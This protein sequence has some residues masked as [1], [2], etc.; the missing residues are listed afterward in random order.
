IARIFPDSMRG[1][2][3]AVEPGTGHVLAL[4]SN[5]SFDPNLFVGGVAPDVWKRLNEDPAKP[6][7]NRATNG[8]Y[9]P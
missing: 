2:V 8:T 9:P 1:A 5:P 7:L 6:L 4:Y 3:V